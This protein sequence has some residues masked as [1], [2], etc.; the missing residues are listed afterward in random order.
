MTLL[1]GLTMLVG[2]LCLKAILAMSDLKGHLLAAHA[3]RA[4]SAF[5]PITVCLL[6]LFPSIL[7]WSAELD[8]LGP[9]V[10]QHS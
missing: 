4:E 3:K 5:C 10:E 1:S 6:E 9:Y 8:K 7:D 2:I